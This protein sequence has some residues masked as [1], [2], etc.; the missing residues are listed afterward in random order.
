MLSLETPLTIRHSQRKHATCSRRWKFVARRPFPSSTASARHRCLG[1]RC[2]NWAKFL[3]DWSFE[4]F[5][6]YDEN[7][8]S[9]WGPSKFF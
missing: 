6:T 4:T 2:C 5:P 1:N 3:K 8:S 7:K 9:E